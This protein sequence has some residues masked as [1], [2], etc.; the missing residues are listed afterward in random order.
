MS[1]SSGIIRRMDDT[2]TREEYEK[3]LNEHGDDALDRIGQ[4]PRSALAWTRDFARMVL[5]IANED[6]KDMNPDVF[7]GDD[8][9]NDDDLEI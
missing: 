2:M 8:S 6:A 9:G 4:S 5:N 7:G 1:D 3:W